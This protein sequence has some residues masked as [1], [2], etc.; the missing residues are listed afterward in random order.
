M[1]LH[2]GSALVVTW[3][4]VPE[5]S[6]LLKLQRTPA[7]K[8]YVVSLVFGRFDVPRHVKSESRTGHSAAHLGVSSDLD[9]H[10]LAPAIQ[11]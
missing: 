10:P 9:V 2:A 5:Q 7:F 11:P 8:W 4:A 3:D 6:W 1:R